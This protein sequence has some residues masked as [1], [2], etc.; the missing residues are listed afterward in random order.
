MNTTRIAFAALISVS[1]AGC[2]S[3]GSTQTRMPTTGSFVEDRDVRSEAVAMDMIIPASPVRTWEALQAV[4]A[5]LELEVTGLDPASRLIS[6]RNQRIRRLGGER[7][8]EWVDCG[9]DV[10]GPVAD[11]AFVDMDVTAVIEDADANASRLAVQVQA[12]GLRRDGGSGGLVC[13]SRNR[14]EFRIRDMILERLGA[15]GGQG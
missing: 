6:S 5:D 14:L 12:R 7:N 11:R 3:G 8:S 9:R 2:A 4:F 10:T 1:L 15:A 13:N